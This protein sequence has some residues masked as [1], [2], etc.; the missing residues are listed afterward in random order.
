MANTKSIQKILNYLAQKNEAVTP[1]A[2]SLNV[3]LKWQTIQ[4]CLKIL[5]QSN[6]IEIISSDTTSLIKLK[7][8][9]KN[10]K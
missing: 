5:Q 4:E 2:L 10:G 6:Q 8:T 7:S 1:S 9:E 3:H